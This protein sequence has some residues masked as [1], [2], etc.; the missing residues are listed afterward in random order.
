[1]ISG[2]A[3]NLK[4]FAMKHPA[5]GKT[6]TTDDYRDAW[7]VG[8]TPQL[9]TGVWV[10]N[11]KP[12]SGGKGFTGGAVAAPI[13]GAFMR[14]A[15]SGKPAIDFVRP[16][17]VV[18]IGIGPTGDCIAPGEWPEK[19]DEYFISGSEPELYCNDEVKPSSH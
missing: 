19:H 17:N 6:G 16:D 12:K 10:G 13:W 18:S 9:V 7:F 11:D 15:V 1:M 4:N 5:A 3:R 8:Y 2:T 14:Q